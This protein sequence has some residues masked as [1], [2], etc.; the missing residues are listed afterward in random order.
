MA[1]LW[2]FLCVGLWAAAYT[3]RDAYDAPEYI[4]KPIYYLTVPIGE[5]PLLVL[6]ATSHLY[7]VTGA[8][9]QF[10]V[11]APFW[12]AAIVL[13]YGQWFVAV[14]AIWRRLR[15][16]GELRLKL[17]LGIVL[18]VTIGYA[19]WTFIELFLRRIT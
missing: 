9:G 11:M 8:E 16:H 12:L 14:P 17:M 19:F 18:A 7:T 10:W 3:Y 6:D 4:A 5:V 1:C 15:V 13:G 2:T